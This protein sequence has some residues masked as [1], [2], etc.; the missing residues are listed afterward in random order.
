MNCFNYEL[1]RTC[2]TCLD[3]ISQNK[4]NSTDINSLKRKPA[5]ENYQMV[6][7]CGSG[8][9]RKQKTLILDLPEQILM[10]KE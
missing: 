9:K 7:Y 3:L 4:T 5:N 6:S 10:E 1:E 2:K 8:Y